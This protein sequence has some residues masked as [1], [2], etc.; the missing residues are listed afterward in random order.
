MKDATE[1]SPVSGNKDAK[2]Q[3]KKSLD[4]KL[5]NIQLICFK[6]GEEEYALKIDQIKEVVQTPSITKMPQC[7]SYVKG[8]ANIRGNIITIVDLA[9]KFGRKPLTSSLI[10][11]A[12]N[13]TLVIENADLRMGILVNEVPKTI[14]VPLSDIE[15]AGNIIHSSSTDEKYVDGVVK[16]DDRLMIMIDAFKILGDSLNNKEEKMAV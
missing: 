2:Q 7:P 11:G 1:K 12:S 5:G 13:F 3:M 8:V 14:N 9:E 4:E 6:Q 10:E 16:L 15:E